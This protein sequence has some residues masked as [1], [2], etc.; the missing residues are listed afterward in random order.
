MNE[1]NKT[2]YIPLYGKAKVSK[3]GIILNDPQAEKIWEAEAFPIRG[4]SK[5][6]W[7]TYNMAMRA[8]IFDDWTK[9]QLRQNKD[10]LVLHIGCGLDSRC[11]RVKEGYN[12]WIDGDFPEVIN[13]RKKYYEENERYHMINFDAS[14]PAYV[15]SLPDNAQ[16]IVILEGISMYLQNE[17]I[18]NLFKALEKKY[19]SLHILMDVYTEFGAKAS[20]YKN[21]INDVGVTKVWGIDDIQ[22]VLSDTNIKCKAEYSFTPDYLV[23]ELSSFERVFFRIMFA[24]SLY[25]KIYRL[26][27]LEG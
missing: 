26:Y 6:K 5:S 21:P 16:A 9:E 13:L 23:N 24:E 7:L 19:S 18:H 8:R 17:Q 4:K 10:A 11:L 20:K 22:S 1:V 27:E 3:K 12:G 25:K 2:L 14:D 15:D